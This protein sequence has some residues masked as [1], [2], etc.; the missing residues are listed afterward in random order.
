MESAKTKIADDVLQQ[1]SRWIVQEVIATCRSFGDIV[2]SERHGYPFIQRSSDV[3]VTLLVSATA[4]L[5]A[6]ACIDGIDGASSDTIRRALERAADTIENRSE[7]PHEQLPRVVAAYLRVIE[8][9]E[10]GDTSAIISAI[11]DCL[12]QFSGVVASG[13]IIN[14]DLG[15][16]DEII[17]EAVVSLRHIAALIGSLHDVGGHDVGEQD[18]GG[19]VG[20]QQGIRRIEDAGVLAGVMDYI[21]ETNRQARVFAKRAAD[22]NLSPLMP[23]A[24][25]ASQKLERLGLI[26]A[27]AHMPQRTVVSSHDLLVRACN[28]LLPLV[29]DN[30]AALPPS[31]ASAIV[32]CCAVVEG[33]ARSIGYSEQS[34]IRSASIMRRAGN[35]VSNSVS[36][37]G[38][39]TESSEAAF[40]FAALLKRAVAAVENENLIEVAQVTLALAGE[41]GDMASDTVKRR[42]SAIV[43]ATAEAVAG[44]VDVDPATIDSPEAAGRLWVHCPQ[45]VLPQNPT[46]EW[47]EAF[48][49]GLSDIDH[50]TIRARFAVAGK[51]IDEVVEWFGAGQ[52]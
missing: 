25:Q 27:V 30:Q 41:A 52:K 32:A 46:S 24:V 31:L 34:L 29:E 15:Q 10:T 21:G 16:H 51:R 2:E 48:A 13:P 5:A 44:L 22:A 35:L 40:D 9:T 7:V 39:D 17:G 28:T 12:V 14:P 19:Q 4:F 45:E 3:G 18:V 20:G 1:A 49:R 50:G 43:A 26:Y 37:T 38:S 11:T 33:M 36:N 47:T 8:T 6:I 42:L 23:L